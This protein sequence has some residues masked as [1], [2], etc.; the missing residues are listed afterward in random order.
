MK[1]IEEGLDLKLDYEK[2]KKA[3]SGYEN[4]IPVIVQDEMTLQVLLL[5]Y[6]NEQALDES[7][8][9][10]IATFW[11]TSRN[12]LWVKGATSGQYL[13]LKDVRVNCEQNSLLF[14]VRL[15]SDGACHTKGLNDRYRKTCYYRRL[16]DGKLEYI[17]GLK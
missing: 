7:L 16:K 11:S 12:E 9:T 5:A 3:A 6:V 1:A 8:K 15:K 13:E 4:I 17:E 2:I 10:G 14:L